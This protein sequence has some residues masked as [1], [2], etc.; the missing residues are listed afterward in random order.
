MD[1]S[2]IIVNWNSK[3][4][5][6]KCIASILAATNAIEFEIVVID[7]ASFDGSGEMLKQC[8]PQVQF[9]QSEK[10][11]GFS[12]ANNEAFRVTHGQYVLFLNPDTEIVGTAIP[13]M[14]G[15]LQQMPNAGSV[16]CKL[17]NA[18]KTV[19]TSC[20]QPFPTILNQFLDSEFLRALWPK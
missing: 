19:Q 11:L 12:K 14:L 2:I 8:Y 4:Y 10:N 13:I 6:R 9:I 1:L 18:D 17:L 16:G 20:I 7:N 15:Y 3:E 5:L